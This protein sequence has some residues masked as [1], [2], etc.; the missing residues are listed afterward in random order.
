M[1]FKYAYKIQ[2][3]SYNFV[4]CRDYHT[5]YDSRIF[6]Y[7]LLEKIGDL[8]AH[9]GNNSSL[10]FWKKEPAYWDG[11]SIILKVFMGS[12]DLSKWPAVTRFTVHF[13]VFGRCKSLFSFFFLFTGRVSPLQL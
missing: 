7:T 9:T 13:T 3:D 8:S 6:Q 12:I 1:I 10:L 2:I 4:Y 11:A 5:I